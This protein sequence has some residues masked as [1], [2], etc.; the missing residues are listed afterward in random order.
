MSLPMKRNLIGSSRYG[1]SLKLNTL[2]F[3]EAM[4]GE[5]ALFDGKHPIDKFRFSTF[6]QMAKRIMDFWEKSLG[7]EISVH[8]FAN[9]LSEYFEDLG[10]ANV[11]FYQLLE[12]IR[13]VGK[14]VQLHSSGVPVKEVQVRSD[15]EPTA[16]EKRKLPKLAPVGT[17]QDAR[18]LEKPMRFKEE[19]RTKKQEFEEANVLPV[20]ERKLT[21]PPEDRLVKPSELFK[22]KTVSPT[23]T[24]LPPI[25]KKEKK[26]EPPEDRLLKPSEILKKR[27]TIEAIKRPSPSLEPQPTAVKTKVVS[28]PVVKQQRLTPPEDSLLKPSEYLKR[29]QKPEKEEPVEHVVTPSMYKTRK[30]AEVERI[31]ITKEDH[32]R[33]L[34]SPKSTPEK[35][36]PSPKETPT[37]SP[38]PTKT[39]TPT[40]KPKTLTK[41]PTKDF[42]IET[43]AK[44]EIPT[45]TTRKIELTAMPKPAIKEE[46]KVEPKKGEEVKA[47]TIVGDTN[48]EEIKGVGARSAQLL[49]EAGY[50]TINKIAQATPEELAKIKGIGLSTAKKII[51]NAKNIA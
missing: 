48:I 6:D 50:D 4:T 42:S 45:K 34:E 21:K 51:E 22:K 29:L 11:N 36:I 27:E 10:V 46:V 9:W 49:R 5:I 38:E 35:A 30:K 15:M 41:E 17:Y 1:V 20:P 24:T 40:E 16:P 25:K 44:K 12:A 14:G 26:I 37:V 43:E 7:V 8:R 18:K 19:E 28:Q 33:V 31:T 39:I 2:E 3:G 13:G 47:K 23:V 32:S